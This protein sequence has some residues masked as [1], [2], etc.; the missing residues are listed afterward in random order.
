MSSKRSP[1]DV[2]LTSASEVFKFLLG[3]TLAIAILFLAGVGV[4]RYFM[5]KL[6]VM[7]PRPTFPN[8]PQ[9]AKP[10]P[11]KAATQAPAAQPAA[12]ASPAADTAASPVAAASPAVAASPGASPSPA[13]SLPPGAYSAK[14]TQPIGLIVRQDPNSDAAQIGGVEYNQDV[15]VLE[16]NADGSWQRV[17][18]GNGQEGWIKG[19]NTEKQ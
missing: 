9:P 14:V 13:P 19:G 15:T 10:S 11:A 18:L 8:D 12:A 2:L 5:S 7:P 6:A 3:F 17:R 1:S 4:T 16:Q